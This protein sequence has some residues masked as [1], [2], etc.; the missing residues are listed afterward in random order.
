MLF[1]QK[2]QVERVCDG[3]AVTWIGREGLCDENCDLT[4]RKHKNKMAA[5]KF[6]FVRLRCDVAVTF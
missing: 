4:R 3:Y 2:Y 5:K 1:V 6:L